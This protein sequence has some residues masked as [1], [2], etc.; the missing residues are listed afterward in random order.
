MSAAESEGPSL[1]DIGM[2]DSGGNKDFS[3]MSDKELIQAGIPFAAI[4]Q[5]REIIAKNGNNQE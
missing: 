1:A 2:G 4:K 3:Q 5:M